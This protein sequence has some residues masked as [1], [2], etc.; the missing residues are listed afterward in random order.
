MGLVRD[1]IDKLTAGPKV[2]RGTTAGALLGRGDPADDR[3]L[4]INCG[5]GFERH[6]HECPEC[7]GPYV[8]DTELADDT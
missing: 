4:C 7:R 8:V 1:L 6:Y 2:Y 5:H 3:Y